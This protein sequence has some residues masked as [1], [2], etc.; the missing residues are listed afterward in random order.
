M[1]WLIA[2]ALVA[3]LL[4]APALPT[5]AA[6]AP[7]PSK[8]RDECRSL[9][10]PDRASAA[11]A[12]RLCGKRVE[13]TGL[14]SETDQVFAN[15]NGTF[16]VEHRYRPVRVNR[17]GKWFPVDTTLQRDN[18]GRIVP[19]AASAD[20]SFSSGGAGPLVTLRR[21][22]AEVSLSSPFGGLPVPT[23]AANTATY[24]EVLPGVDLVLS[25]DVDGYTER[26]VIK[27]R[28][29][30]AQKALA[31][32]DF[33]VAGKGASVKTDAHGNLSVVDAK[34]QALFVGSTPLMWDATAGQAGK[35]KA[36]NKGKS[37]PRHKT[38]KTSATAGAVSVLPDQGMLADP[39][40]VYPVTID[41]ELTANRGGWGLVDSATPDTHYWNVTNDIEAGTWNDGVDRVRSYLTMNAGSAL[42]GAHVLSATL[43]LYEK[44]APSCDPRAVE[45]HE[46]NGAVD[47]NLTWNT[48]PGVGAL[49]QSVST[50]KGF[51]P[52]GI[53]GASSCPAGTVG[54]DVTAA[55]QKAANQGSSAVTLVVTAADETDTNSWKQFDNNPTLTITTNSIPQQP[56]T[57]STT[58]A[59]ACATGDARPYIGSTTPQLQ[60]TTGDAEGSPL[61]TTFEWFVA[62]GSKIGQAS[63]SRMAGSPVLVTVP[64]GAFADGGTYAWRAASNDGMD[65]G[66]WSPWCE[67]AVDVT[68]PTTAPDV[69]SNTYRKDTW[70]GA[71]DTAGTFD[72][73]G[74]GITDVT[75]YLYGLD[76][77]PPTTSV[78]ATGLGGTASVSITPPSDGPHVL[79][80]QSVDRAGNAS[81]TT[82]YH[83]NV[84]V[85]A[86]IA[87]ADGDTV[88]GKIKLSGVAQPG[89]TS[90][91]Y[92]WRRAE[93]DAWTA[94]PAS[95]VTVASGGAAVSWPLSTT[96]NGAFPDLIWNI[97]S[98]LAAADAQ[99]IPRDGPLQIRATF[100][101][102]A[103]AA[104][105]PV[106]ITF[107][108]NQASAA[109][110]QVGPGS[111]NAV[112]GNYTVSSSDVSA[113]SGLGVGR[114][115]NTR[116]A[117]ATDTANMFGPGWVSSVSVAGSSA[118]YTELTVV[119]SLVQ[120]GLPDGTTL[121]FTAKATTATGTTFT[122]PT[123]QDDLQLTYA[124][125]NDTY[126]LSK[127]GDATVIFTHLATVDVGS[128][129]PTAVTPAGSSTSA[130]Y[131]WEKATVDGT[132]VVRP[133]RVLASVPAGVDCTAALVR[134]CQALTFTYAAT[135]TATGSDAGQWGDY[136]GRLASV[137]Y[138]A[139]AP[140]TVAMRT[141][142]M[143]RYAYDSTG[144]LRQQWDPRRDYTTSSGATV[145]VGITYSYDSD[146]L[147]TTLTPPAQEPWQLGYTT[148]PS[149]SGKGRLTT[150]TR[151]ALSAGTATTTVVYNVPIS[152]SGAPY[153]LSPLATMSW[154]QNEA[155]VTG[156]AV[157]SPGHK[158]TGN[159]AA[160]QLPSSY[161]GATI[162]YFDTNGHPVNVARPGGFID[163]TWYDAYGATVR[164]LT[165]G[166]RQTALN[167]STSVAG[168]AATA[169]RL[170]T[171]TTYS[172][173]GQR[174]LEV[175][176]S[177]HDV[178][179]S[180][181]SIVRG[182][183]HTVNRYDEGA[184]AYG[185][186][187]NLVTTSTESVRYINATGLQVD[188]DARTTVT[189]Y[190]WTLRQPTAVTTDPGGL[191]LTKRTSYDPGTGQVTATTNPAG[192]T[193]NTTPATQLTTYYRS[194]TGS[195][196]PECDNHPEWTGLV[197]T[198]GPGGQ[199]RS[200]PELPVTV[201]T[202]DLYGQPRVKTEKSSAG[203]LRTTTTTY[204]NAGRASAVTVT[205][206]DSLGTAL[207]IT[208][209]VYDPASGQLTATESLD[210]SG[211]V[212]ARI[213]RAY[214]TLGRITSYTDA[215]GNTTTTTYD[216]ASR[217]TTITD[218]KGT[219]TFTYDSGWERR[220]LLT[221]VQDSQGGTFTAEY[222]AEGN[223]F[224]ENWPNN[225]VVTRGYNEAGTQTGVV[226]AQTGCGQADCTLYSAYS[227][228]DAHN[229]Q[230]WQNSTLSAEWDGYDAAGRLNITS[231]TVA[232][233]CTSRAYGFDTNS[234]R[235]VL[236]T[237]N[238]ASDGTC[239][240]STQANSRS[241]RYDN[242][243]RL[244]GAYTYDALGRTVTLPAA[245]TATGSSDTQ[246]TYYA[247]DMARTSTQNGRSATYD[248]D[249]IANRIRSWTDGSVSKRN[250]YDNDTDV[251]AW[252][253][254]G[255]GNT[256]RQIPGITGIA[257][258]FTNTTGNVYLISDLRG[259]FVGGVVAGSAGLASTSQYD[260]FGTPT[261]A[262]DVG[263]RRYGW[264]GQTQRAADNPAGLVAMGARTYNPAT[265]RFLSVD[266]VYGGNANAYDYC[267]GDGVNCTDTSGMWGTWYLNC[268]GSWRSNYSG[269]WTSGYNFNI[270]C[271][272]GHGYVNTFAYAWPVLGAVV[273]A[274]IGMAGINPGTILGGAFAG[275]ILG[276]IVPW[277]YSTFCRRQDGVYFNGTI[278]ERWPNAYGRKW[279]STSTYPGWF[280][281]T[282]H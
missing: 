104:S 7:K 160:G 211:S 222:D 150:V 8:T 55:T 243:D 145:H 91:T 63:A 100:A 206:A 62:G 208:R 249:V 38:M 71:A 257:A 60:V 113:G 19:A 84:G 121:G 230:R 227:G 149:D 61:T 102:P 213:T 239:Q 70:S 236:N 112:T 39:A 65:T 20:M 237:F 190:D 182:R 92:Q 31:K 41:P 198:T 22:G 99:R 233:Q 124:S 114:T 258:T 264:L 156:T 73:G 180:D 88:A 118:P 218:P 108:R 166:N 33:P 252:T 217:P 16:T 146:G 120:V 52:D 202:Y 95:D 46:S 111:V 83:F 207:P 14:V 278:Y 220:G 82:A 137:D 5:P 228:A 221:Q 173:D 140:D 143:A 269:F 29:A 266:S 192:G 172:A 58:P 201:T 110:T 234:N 238:P 265:G 64:A 270:R 34:G 80:V 181:G 184:P 47:A 75:S 229:R 12:A 196:H 85:G 42:A 274:Y 17:A 151:S 147:L 168:Q 212:T 197:C 1:A 235:T 215:D 125:A 43:N 74:A 79:Y 119:G 132:D 279:W 210:A 174:Q 128:Y 37:G 25:A 155:P 254:E 259:N 107:D 240:M 214:D 267:S 69:S 248:L 177:E 103:G 263:N 153:D 66:P 199:A 21:D 204:D 89:T 68:A 97:E 179:L 165:A 256:S 10:R 44:W 15:A 141:I 186:P 187:Y 50:A 282:C 133:T 226:Y 49:Q 18:A 40:T 250:H 86:P 164:T 154:G 35:S 59:V 57:A 178:T 189:S 148:L 27:N 144:R 167:S 203:T 130:T 244:T 87:P 191:S 262:G 231:T 6:A 23:L 115:F 126:T 9:Q 45:V 185:G 205:T 67:F 194:G 77:N 51:S 122:S 171:I 223:A 169:A 136:T 159:Q 48:Q 277:Y 72:L 275:A 209:N 3:S 261:Q 78:N 162:T 96:G 268:G 255:N 123:G 142:T 134:G 170:S 32:L 76:T 109:V 116:R 175:L 251:P 13:V 276:A 93:T 135:T 242:A 90:I 26:L 24:S 225:I 81:P 94:I 30:G 281:E 28:Q 193:S 273:G 246:M 232:G 247:N 200:G 11:M 253:D 117:T 127:T 53:G 106:K 241:W 224:R 280:W 158:P 2:I 176:G 4:E 56:T 183:T 157:F 195:G 101:N 152:G 36:G 105:S 272:V 138:T 216:L 260:P 98:T 54:F 129:Q 163:T 139:Y 131:A 219:Q 161:E 245:D 188:A 271:A